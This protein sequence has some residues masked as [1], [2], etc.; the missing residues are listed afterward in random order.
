MANEM[1]PQERAV[2][3]RLQAH[4]LLKVLTDGVGMNPNDRCRKID[5]LLSY[6]QAT[7]RAALLEARRGE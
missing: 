6:A 1:T 7:R 3:P 4:E 2:S 5:L